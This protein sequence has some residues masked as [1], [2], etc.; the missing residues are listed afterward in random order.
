M[1]GFAAVLRGVGAAVA[2]LVLATGIKM[3]ASLGRTP[4]V[5]GFLIVTVV[6][7]ALLRWPLVPILLALIPLSVL[8]AWI[9]RA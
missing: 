6:A 5:L 8:V 1:P 7:I 2:G 9:R 4:R 3:A